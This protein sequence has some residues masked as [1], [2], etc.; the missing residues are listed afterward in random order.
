MVEITLQGA[1]TQIGL[2][3]GQQLKYAIQLAAE[4]FGPG[5]A[6]Q[7]TR[8]QAYAYGRRLAKDMQE[9]CPALM[10]EIHAT[11]KG[12]EIAE[13]DFLAYAFRCWN[14]LV[15]HPAT[16][17]CY[18]LAAHDPNRGPIIA[19][20]LEDLPPFYLLE[21]V[22]PKKGYAFHGITWAGM[23]WAVRGMNQAG[24]AIGQASSFAG[25]RFRAGAHRFPFDLYARAFYAQRWA[26]QNADNVADAVEIIRGFDCTSTFMLGD[27]SGKSVTLEVCGK[28]HALREPDKLGVMTGGVFESPQ[29]IKALLE[30]GIAHDWEQGLRTAQRVAA[31]L[32]GAQ[33]KTT[34]EWMEKYLRTEQAAGGWCH[35]GLQAA[36]IACPATGEFWVGGFRP[37]VSG[38]KE[39]STKTL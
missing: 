25:T 26:I 4:H 17:A 24:L 6:H 7:Y 29:L 30:E 38:F 5:H 10:E 16:L 21:T 36:T 33:R 15:D 35:D 19:G 39:Y 34:M 8:R 2:E 27:R 9:R 37:C 18:N 1:P 23:A 3:R 14:A 13:D 11:G 22:R 32:R 28:L 20:V 31:K 12:A